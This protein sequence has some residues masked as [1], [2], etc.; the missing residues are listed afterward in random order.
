MKK[1][2]LL[3]FL[4]ISQTIFGQTKFTETQKLATTCKVWGFLKYYHPKVANGDFNWDKQLFEVL[5]KIE[6]T[7]TKEEFSLILENWIDS[8]GEVKETAPIIHPKDI[9][10][11]DKNFDLSW[12]DKNKLF[13]KKLSK[14]LKFIED[15]RFQGEQYYVEAEEGA[16]NISVKNG[17]YAEY[18]FND[19]KERILALFMYW[20]LMEYFFP[21]KYLM[22][23]KWDI[24]LE[25]MLPVFIEAENL[26]DFYVA[27]QKLTVRLNDSHVVFYKYGTK[28][29][30]LPV[31]CKIINEKMI[32]TEILDDY[33]SKTDDI[34]V[35][36]V[37]TKVNDK[38]IKEIIL[39]YR[40]L[41]PASNEAYYLFKIVE[42]ALSVSSD[43]IKLEFLKEGKEGK[44]ET[45]TINLVDYNLNRFQL[46]DIS[47]VRIKKEKFK[48]LE[49]NI[50]Y[51]NMGVIK[52]KDL[53]EMIEKLKSTKAIVF[54]IRNYPNGTFEEIS[55]FLNTKEKTFAIYTKPDLSYPGKFKWTKG[56]S[57]G[58]ENNN[59]YKGKVVVLLNEESLS[60]SEWTAMC[61]QTA[62]NTTIIG[63]Q[64]AGA[65]GNVSGIDY[66]KAFHSQFTG[67]GVYYPN[68]KETQRIGIVPDIEVKPTIK[69]IQEGE[70]EV[71]DRA[72]KFIKTGK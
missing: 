44:H 63:S 61:F 8:L 9:E 72:L 4:V 3:L 45:K 64:T 1:I 22:D 34:K 40:D 41:I 66:M 42:S 46:K 47:K 70:D 12:I 49:N 6:Q 28:R 48:I 5:P 37:I 17:N 33:L 26:D 43:N 11:F 18:K 38:T 16:G 32:V 21:Y 20:N 67:I 52:V 30:F 27:M 54:D 15:N 31:V 59:N 69:G 24:T 68:K 35:G 13:S 2:S 14:K 58:S 19:K 53:P 51:V 57:C 23:K 62:G 10:Y 60:Q 55:K 56:T 25:E 50:G 65:D 29:H 39:D 7:K 36:D 71:L